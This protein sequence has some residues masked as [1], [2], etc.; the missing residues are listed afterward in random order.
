M[1]ARKVSFMKHEIKM[2]REDSS[3]SRVQVSHQESKVEEM[4]ETSVTGSK[5]F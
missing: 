5:P 2:V 4:V 3:L 1:P